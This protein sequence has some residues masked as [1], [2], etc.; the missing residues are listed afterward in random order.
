[1]ENQSAAAS[2][3]TPLPGAYI[4]LIACLTAAS[5]LGTA[6]LTILPTLA[7]AVARSY[8]IPPVWIGYQ[9]SLVAF[10]MT[11]SLLFLGNASRRWGAV[12]VVQCGVGAIALAL[13]LV[14]LPSIAA[15]LLASA[16]MG[17]GYGLVMPANSHLM[18]RFTPRANLN[19]VF[20]IQQTGIPLGAI[21]A[22]SAAPSIAVAWSWQWAV[23]L[24]TLLV[25]L[26]AIILGVQRARW[27]DDRDA[28]ALLLRNP[29]GGVSLVL[30]SAR[31]RNLSLSGF[32]FSG[33]Q[34]CVATYT[35]VALVEQL[36]YGLVQAGLML[37]AA[38]A[39][40]L[41]S[42]LCCGWLADRSGDSIG[43]LRWLAVGMTVC[44]TASLTLTDAWPLA[45]VCVLFVGHGAATVGWPGT[46]LAEV[47]RLC[48]PGQVSSGTSG[49]L[50]FSNLGKMLAPLAFV[51]MQAQTGSYSIAF[52]MVGALG[53]VAVIALARAARD[54]PQL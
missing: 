46:Y 9:F 1:M 21:L 17:L 53:L 10:F 16:I 47:G 42:R 36:G 13:G 28:S 8:G 19:M 41:A 25:V 6:A 35:V 23:L 7:P 15:L 49:S 2:A 22:A 38:Q 45:A 14:L 50:L 34:F 12:R 32:C 27:D 4:A 43:V 51:A 31:L 11:L 20:S 26:L 18:M 33:A 40:G 52:G 24:V 48:P 5:M 44:G 54:A 39:A 37:S 3:R 30:R 29:F